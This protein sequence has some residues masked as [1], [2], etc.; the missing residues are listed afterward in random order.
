MKY[1]LK[2][3]W[4]RVVCNFTHSHRKKNRQLVNGSLYSC[5]TCGCFHG[6]RSYATIN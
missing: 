3:F 6:D 4:D 2:Y 1:K 5:R